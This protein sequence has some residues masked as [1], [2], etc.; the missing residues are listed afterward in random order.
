LK[1]ELTDF[2]GAVSDVLDNELQGGNVEIS[3]EGGKDFGN[4]GTWIESVSQVI[5]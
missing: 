2:G 1:W 3:D 5:G 4:V